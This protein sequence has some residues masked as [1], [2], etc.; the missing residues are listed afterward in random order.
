MF[1]PFGSVYQTKTSYNMESTVRPYELEYGETI[2]INILAYPYVFF[3]G[4][5][6]K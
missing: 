6:P 1:I 5:S 4:K 2:D 3:K